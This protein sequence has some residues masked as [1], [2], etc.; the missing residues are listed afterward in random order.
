MN[1]RAFRKLVAR[2]PYYKGRWGYMRTAQAWVRRLRAKK[3]LEIGTRRVP[4]FKH[5]DS[6]DEIWHERIT[7]LHDARKVPWPIPSKRYD[8]VV[9]L[10]V[11]EHLGSRQRIAFSQV[12]RIARMAIISIPYKWNCPGDPHHGIDDAV[13]RR[14]TGGGWV[15]AKRIGIRKIYLFVF[16]S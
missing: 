9:A 10:Q 6:L 16:D 8:I 5:S 14:W 4:L 15:K 2:D 12:R 13:M 3:I 7:Y 1:R 11:W